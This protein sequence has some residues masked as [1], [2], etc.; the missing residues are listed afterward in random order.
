MWKFLCKNANGNEVLEL[1]SGTGRVSIPLLKEGLN[2]TGI[3]LSKSFCDYA[4]KQS[5]N[6]GFDNAKFIHGNI[7]K[8]NL[9]KRFDIIIIAYNSLLHLLKNEQ[10]EACFKCVKNHLKANG[11][12]YIDIYMP[13]PL[14]YYRPENLRYSTIEY[15]DSQINEEVTIEETNNY[16]PDKEIN[17]L[18]WYYSSK[19]KKDFLIS[20]FSTRMY[21]PDTMNRMLIE[22]GFEI[23]NL[24]GDYNLNLFTEESTLQIYELGI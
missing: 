5:S 11:K 20:Q 7:T 2:I 23:L 19:T 1:A 9:K 12:F 6:H 13:S 15:F 8:F 3:D 10:V 17:Q 21:W 18:T 16:D 4:L 14:H 22:A 24:W